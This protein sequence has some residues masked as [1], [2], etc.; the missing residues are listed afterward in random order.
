[1][2]IMGNTGAQHAHSIDVRELTTNKV[3]ILHRYFY[4]YY[5]VITPAV[6]SIQQCYAFS[7][8]LA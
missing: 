8:N 5:E 1:M 7:L 4:R 6:Y 3:V 2:Y